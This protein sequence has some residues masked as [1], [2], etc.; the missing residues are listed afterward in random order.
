MTIEVRQATQMTGAEILGVDLG[1][2]EVLGRLT[3]DTL[4]D[5]QMNLL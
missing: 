2:K 5:I 3:G 4:K 1:L